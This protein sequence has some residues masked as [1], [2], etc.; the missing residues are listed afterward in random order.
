[1]PKNLVRT[2]LLSFLFAASFATPALAQR[3]RGHR[4][5]VTVHGPRVRVRAPRPHVV[6]VTPPAPVV[7]VP[8]P[9][10]HVVVR[11]TP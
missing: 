10:R 7:V 9:P 8:R 6:V 11:V 5:H 1:M 4:V 3:G 2:L